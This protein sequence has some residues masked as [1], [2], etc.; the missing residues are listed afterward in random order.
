MKRL[1]TIFLISNLFILPVFA[2]DYNALRKLGRGV[3][4]V[5]F[6]WVE[7]PLQMTKVKKETNELGGM[8]WGALKG[9]AFMVGRT[10]VG[11]YEVVTFLIPSY[12]PVV[13]PEFIFKED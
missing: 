2:Q 8:F 6:G 1:F 5:S 3:V 4:N 13:E 9:L 10:F 7:V 11:T 12:A